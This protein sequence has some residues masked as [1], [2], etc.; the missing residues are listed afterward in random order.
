MSAET[1]KPA[2]KLLDTL[3]SFDEDRV[4][5]ELII[6][7][8]QELP[9]DWLQA[10]RKV[11][12]DS[13][14]RRTNWEPVASIPT[15]VADWLLRELNFDVMREPFKATIAMLKRHHLDHFILTNK[16]L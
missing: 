1:F 7:R 5:N 6:K 14:R 2:P 13:V 15:E 3:V 10:N 4:T 9:D 12:E 11:R 8:T 16:Q